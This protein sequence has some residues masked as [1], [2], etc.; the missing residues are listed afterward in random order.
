[1]HQVHDI[2]AWGLYRHEP[3]N[4]NTIHA[5]SHLIPHLLQNILIIVLIVQYVVCLGRYAQT[6]FPMSLDWD[7]DEEDEKNDLN[8]REDQDKDGKKEMPLTNPT[9]FAET[10]LTL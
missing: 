7:D 6:E 10:T 3:A 1:M 5:I 2:L 4:G 8:K 9:F